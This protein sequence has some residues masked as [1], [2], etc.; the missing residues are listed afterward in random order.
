MMDEQLYP[1]N[2]MGPPVLEAML[3]P[4]PMPDEAVGHLG[5]ELWTYA[6]MM[7]PGHLAALRDPHAHFRMLHGE[8]MGAIEELEKRLGPGSQMEALEDGEAEI[9]RRMPWAE[10]ELVHPVW[11]G[12]SDEL[13]L[14]VQLVPA[15]V[16]EAL[17]LYRLNRHRPVAAV[18]ETL[19]QQR[20]EVAVMLLEQNGTEVLAQINRTVQ[21]V[22]RNGTPTGSGG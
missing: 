16:L 11:D 19:G 10:P 5:M 3:V 14:E 20:L 6:A 18:L 17:E 21:Q 13:E 8:W 9:R 7:A 4:C 1:W 2:Q 12:V 22:G 15:M